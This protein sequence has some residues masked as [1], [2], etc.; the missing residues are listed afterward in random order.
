MYCIVFE[1]ASVFWHCLL[2][3][4]SLLCRDALIASV[5]DGVRAS[6]NRDV[7]V[8][9]RLTNRGFRLGKTLPLVLLDK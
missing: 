6:G 9:M 7:H 8:K 2:T 3:I 4:D 5:V 1:D